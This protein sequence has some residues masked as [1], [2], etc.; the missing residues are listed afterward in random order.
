MA[1]E[2]KVPSEGERI[3]ELAERLLVSYVENPQERDGEAAKARAALPPAVVDLLDKL[4]AKAD[5]Y[6]DALLVAL[7][8][9]IVRGERVDIRVR[10]PG[11]RSASDRIGRL[12]RALHIRGVVGAYQNIGKNHPVLARGNNES[13]DA[14]LTWGALKA[15]PPELEAAYRYLAAGVAATARRVE[16]RPKIR[17]ASLTFGRVMLLLSEMLESPSG[18]AHEQYIVTALIE[19]SLAVEGGPRVAT[20]SMSAS[21]RS[22]RAAGDIEITHGGRLQESV[23]VSANPWRDKL[24]QAE[25][26]LREYG[27]PR[28]HIVAKAAEPSLYKAVVSATERDISVL[29]VQAVVPVLVATLDRRGR[30][31][32]LTRLYEL[33]DEKVASPNLVNAFVGR[34]R[35]QELMED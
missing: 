16:P 12:L 10:D 25:D 2:Q 32:A 24:P 26:A 29:D 3:V 8:V 23:E 11:G 27:L 30:E 13:F 18:G 28:A 19:A 7:A 6:R 17:P 20:K 15:T 21:D 22:S 9:P 31:F 1:R 5:S 35:D 14:V 4:L 33:L 34:L